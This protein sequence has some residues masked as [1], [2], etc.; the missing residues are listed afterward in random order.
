MFKR[1]NSINELERRL[2]IV[3]KN[4]IQQTL[5][6]KTVGFKPWD[7]ITIGKDRGKKTDSRYFFTPPPQKTTEIFWWFCKHN[8]NQVTVTKGDSKGRKKS[9]TE[10]KDEQ[11][12][13]MNG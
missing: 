11:K 12:L 8:I 3:K 7:G 13:P 5:Q 1:R 4:G 6:K 2:S 9:R 10:S